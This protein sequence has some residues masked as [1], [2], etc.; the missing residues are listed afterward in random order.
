[1]AERSQAERSQA[2]LS[3]AAAVPPG[4]QAAA[5]GLG[6]SPAVAIGGLQSGGESGQY[7]T[8]WGLP[9]YTISI[10]QRWVGHVVGRKGESIREVEKDTGAIVKL[11]HSAKAMG[12]SVCRIY[13]QMNAATKA[14]DLIKLKLAAIDPQAELPQGYIAEEYR[15]DHKMIG[16]ILGRG[17]ETM[18]EIQEKSGAHVAYDRFKERGSAND[19]VRLVGRKEEIERAIDLLEK[20]LGQPRVLN[21]AG[22]VSGAAALPVNPDEATHEIRIEQALVGRIIGKGKVAIKQISEHTGARIQI[23]QSAQEGG[24]SIIRIAGKQEAA[25]EAYKQLS[26]Q[27]DY[28]RKKGTEI[29]SDWLCPGCGSLQYRRDRQCRKC[30]GEQ[31]PQCIGDDEIRVDQRFIGYIIGPGGSTLNSIKDQTGAKVFISQETK[32]QGYSIVRVA[33]RGTPQNQAAQE[34]IQQKL[35]EC[36]NLSSNSRALLGLGAEALGQLT[37]GEEQWQQPGQPSSSWEQAEPGGAAPWQPLDKPALAPSWQ[38]L[39]ASVSFAKSA[40]PAQQP[41]NGCGGPMGAPDQA[42]QFQPLGKGIGKPVGKSIGKE[43]GKDFGKAVGGR[44]LGKGSI[45]EAEQDRTRLQVEAELRLKEERQRQAEQEAEEQR[46]AEQE[47]EEKRKA[48]EEAEEAERQKKER[49]DR[50]AAQLNALKQL[51]SQQAQYEQEQ[52][53]GVILPMAMAPQVPSFAAFAPQLQMQMAFPMF[54]FGMQMPFMHM[55][56]M[57][58]P[59]AQE[60]DPID[61]H[62][63]RMLNGGGQT[64]QSE[65]G[66]QERLQ[67]LNAQ[68]AMMRRQ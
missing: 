63:N 59:V 36:R 50:L 24:F 40:P 46:R 30:G 2:Q 33:N 49:L 64:A 35:N 57:T 55:P 27:L 29:S 60:P 17:G 9:V 47:A 68:F 54:G 21:F 1:M 41:W 51:K 18:K 39:D 16:L 45:F 58:S 20:K 53:K 62:L 26:A 28:A 14:N 38:P 52:P 61:Q 13:G 12:T 31:T 5:L 4:A 32:D 23:D 43:T 42:V 66:R 56:T 65:D 11:D 7:C 19:S 44:P 8:N 6:I 34:L 48:E 10:G 67:R 3:A 22:E 25:A 37:N 15:I